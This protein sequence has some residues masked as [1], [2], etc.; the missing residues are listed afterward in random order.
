MKTV[1]IEKNKKE[2]VQLKHLLETNH[3]SLNKYL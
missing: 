2:V 1:A 3:E